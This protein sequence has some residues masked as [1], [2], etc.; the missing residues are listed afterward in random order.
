MAAKEW[1]QIHEKLMKGYQGV[2]SQIYTQFSNPHINSKKEILRERDDFLSHFSLYHSEWV[3]LC[4]CYVS[5]HYRSITPRSEWF[6][7]QTLACFTHFCYFNIPL[8]NLQM[9]NDFFGEEACVGKA[10]AVE[11]CQLVFYESVVLLTC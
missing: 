11:L 5:Y 7:L 9:F 10:S 8:A 4:V 2:A 1:F 3:F 6:T